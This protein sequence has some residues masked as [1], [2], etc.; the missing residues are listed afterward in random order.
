MR[1][2]VILGSGT[3]HGVPIIGCHCPVCRSSDP[4]NQRTRTGV[5]VH[6]GEGTFLIDTPPELRIQLLREQIDLVHAVV[7]THSHADHIFGLDDLRLFGY[8]LNRAVP[9]YCEPL[10]ERQLRAAFSYAFDPPEP[11]LHLGAIPKL[12]IRPLG[13]DPIELLGETVVP[14]RLI[15]GKLPVLGFRI[16]DVAFCTDVSFM[17][18][19]SYAR[20]QN[21]D[22]L[23]IDALRDQPH[24]THFGIPQ[25]LEVIE[26]TKP[27]RAYL[28]HVSHHLDY[29]A[30]N[31]RLPSGVELAYD[32]LRL[33]Y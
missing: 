9:L 18:E 7:Y 13:L 8:R 6:T 2:L 14:I 11:D 19:E 12:E 29:A 10:V 1:E 3:S 23:I 17:P 33:P 20:L 32:G 25:A 16:G 15:H 28:T 31:A 22:V 27:R 4:R 24:A 5:A 21:L 26:R 30:T